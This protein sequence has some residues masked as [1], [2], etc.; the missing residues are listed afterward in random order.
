MSDYQFN[1]DQEQWKEIPEFPGY[2]V[3]DQGRVRSYW[4]QISFGYRNGTDFILDS[5]P[6]RIRKPGI[7]KRGKKSYH[8]VPLYR[9]KKQFSR[10]VHCLVMLAFK[11][12]RPQGMDV[13]HN[14]NNGLNNRFDNLRYDTRSG[15]HMDKHK[16]GTMLYGEKCPWA[17]LADADIMNIRQAFYTRFL[18]L[19]N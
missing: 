2:E 10:E 19:Q 16:H 6:Q 9:D 3:S 4:R 18:F 13:C 14:D 15:N 12:P 8:H 11:G 5:Q 1:P 17:I 7:N